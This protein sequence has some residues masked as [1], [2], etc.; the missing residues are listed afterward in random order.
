[1]IN[2]AVVCRKK[3]FDE[4]RLKMGWW[5]YPVPDFEWAFYPLE[6]GQAIDKNKLAQKGHDVIFWEDWVWNDFVGDAPIPIYAAIVDSNTSGR[7]KKRYEGRAKQADVLLIDQD[8]LTHFGKTG[9]PTFRWQYAVN[10]HVFAPQ[11]KTI[12]VGYHVVRTPGRSALTEPIRTL[13]RENGYSLTDGGGMTITQYANRIGSARI[14][15]HKATREQCRSHRFFDALSSASCLLTDRVWG[16]NEDRFMAGSHFVEWQSAADLQ[17]QIV[18]LLETGR[19]QQIAD[20]GR[21][22]IMLHH[23][24]RTRAAQLKGIINATR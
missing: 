10:E 6:D 24:W 11:Q 19:W 12:D 15:V 22:H 21:A 18:D 7:R 20:A 14:V 4:T 9:R 3:G 13:C 17:T 5:S 23:T 16:V 2:V 1:M 8:K